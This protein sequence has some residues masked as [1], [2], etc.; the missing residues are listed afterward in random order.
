MGYVKGAFGPM[1]RESNLGGWLVLNGASFRNAEYPE[2]AKQ[3]RENYAKTNGYVPPD[4]NMTPLTKE[5]LQSKPTG[6]VVR[7]FAICPS[8]A[9]CGLTGTI[10][11]FN[12]DSSL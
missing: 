7:G 8:P 5:P 9:I 1:G 2:L 10:M 3:L 4:P 6:E 11:P 12:L